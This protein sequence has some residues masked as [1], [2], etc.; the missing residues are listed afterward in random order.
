MCFKKIKRTIKV[1]V[2]RDNEKDWSV[3]IPLGSYVMWGEHFF[4]CVLS[5]PLSCKGCEANESVCKLMR[6]CSSNRR[7][8]N[9]VIFV[10]A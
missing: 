5:K 4:R 3:D 9:N 1:R 10:K 6:C 2:V 8:G 7:D